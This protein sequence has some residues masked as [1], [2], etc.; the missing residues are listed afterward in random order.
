MKNIVFS[1]LLSFLIAISGF[2]QIKNETS[3]PSKSIVLL[4]DSTYE[5]KEFTKEKTLIYKGT[6][7]SVNPEIRQGRFYFFNKQGGVSATGSYNQDIPYGKWL[8]FDENNDTLIN[9]NYSEVW[10][11]LQ[12]EALNYQID[13]TVINSLKKKDKITMNTDGTFY[14]VTRMPLFKGGDP[15]VEFKKYI[16]STII[17]PI[18]AL[19]KSLYGNINVQFIIDS[20]GKI[21]DPRIFNP[22]SPDLNIEAIRVLANSPVWEPGYQNNMPVNV[23]YNW[24]FRF[25]PFENY[26][27]N[28][29]ISPTGALKAEYPDSEGDVYYLVENMPKFNGGEPALEFRKHIAQNLRYPNIAAKNGITGRVIVQ[30]IVNSLGDVENATVVVSADPQLDAEAIRVVNTSPKWTPG[31]QKGVPVSVVFKFPISFALQ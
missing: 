14:E 4:K 2:C 24:T 8:Y 29:Q 25:S 13:M 27:N 15:V 5:I 19:G 16:D 12:T 28:S 7:S 17:L 1:I 23:L 22:K 10:N 9:I 3:N 30:F 31:T 26:S 21:R 20:G 11:Y 18:Y 6:L